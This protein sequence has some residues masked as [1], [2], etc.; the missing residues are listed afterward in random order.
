MPEDVNAFMKDVYKSIGKSDCNQ[1]VNDWIDT[2]LLQLN[3][4]LSGS[5]KNGIPVGRVTEIAGAES[6]GKTALATHIAIETQKKG[7]LVIFLDYEHAFSMYKAKQAGLSDKEGML[8]YKQPT[9]AEEGF[10]LI[11]KLADVVKKHNS[12]RMITVIIDSVATMPT[13]AELEADYEKLNMKTNLSLAMV[14][15][16]C[17]RKV[18]PVVNK[19]NITLL[20]INQLRDNPGATY[21]PK[22]KTP[23]GKALKF[24][25]SVRLQLRKA[26]KITVEKTKEVIGE[27]IEVSNQKNKVS[28]PF[29]TCQYISDFKKGVN[30]VESHIEYAKSKGWLGNTKGWLEWNGQKV[31]KKELI[32]DLIQ[33]NELY[34]KFLGLFVDE[35]DDD[36]M[37]GV[38]FDLE[39]GE[40]E[41]E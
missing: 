40:V 25:A 38:D 35:P 8:I 14:M 16:R 28:I 37:D 4:V 21:G 6:S 30:F 9:S 27:V 26:S 39:T 33:D 20:M 36:E 15:S 32:E 23:G 10:A 2:G 7:G 34:M 17:L 29:R 22:T 18:V 13:L 1:D 3:K 41:T 11:E 12:D 24:Y 5:Y 19:H 31:R